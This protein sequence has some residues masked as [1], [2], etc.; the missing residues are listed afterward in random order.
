MFLDPVKRYVRSRV[1]TVMLYGTGNVQKR[2]E[3]KQDLSKGRNNKER[4]KKEHS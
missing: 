4:S 1:Y 2:T 3:E